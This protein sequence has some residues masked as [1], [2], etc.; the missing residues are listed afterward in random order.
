FTQMHQ[1]LMNLCVNARDAMPAGGT[2]TLAAENTRLDA[3]AAARSP[4][5]K[6]GN[7]LCISVAD[8]GQG[9]S[10]EQMEK[11]FQPLFTTKSPG[12]GTGLGLSTSLTI[13]KNHGGFMKVESDVGLGA[14]FQLFLP[15]ATVTTAEETTS[16]KP[17][18]PAGKGETVLVVDDEEAMLALTRTALENYGY[19]VL[20]AASGS[21][22]VVRFSEN[23][24]AVNLVITDLEMP[25]M[26]GCAT[27]G[28][29]R[30]IAPGVKIIIA[31]GSEQENVVTEKHGIKTD[32]F[33]E[34][35]FTTEKLLTTVHRILAGQ[36]RN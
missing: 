13:V 5:A 16:L 9:I 28:A 24:D 21:E 17:S 26:D 29:L 25:F 14:T 27:I 19:R 2:L 33:I 23:R 8:T 18:P 3:A 6:P 30:K 35:P 15:A 36:K 12:K 32:A 34:K 20:T 7:Y 11:I 10:A 1:V 31:S 4:G 22:A